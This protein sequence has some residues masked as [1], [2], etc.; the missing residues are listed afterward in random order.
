MVFSVLYSI[1]QKGPKT[2]AKMETIFIQFL[3]TK[4]LLRMMLG[5]MGQ[6]VMPTTTVETSQIVQ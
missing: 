2:K 1:V 3:G 5:S 4:Y 6:N